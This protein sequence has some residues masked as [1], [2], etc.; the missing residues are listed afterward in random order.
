[1]SPP[2]CKRFGQAGFLQSSPAFDKRR[3]RP[4]AGPPGG[5]HETANRLEPHQLRNARFLPL[6]E[7]SKQFGTLSPFPSHRG[8]SG[9]QSPHFF[10]SRTPFPPRSECWRRCQKE[11]TGD[12]QKGK[13]RS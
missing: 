5:P 9:W 11:L 6:R 2:A 13:E 4:L 7:S 8:S 3:K 12:V 10:L 1:P